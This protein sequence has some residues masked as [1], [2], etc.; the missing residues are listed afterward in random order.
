MIEIRVVVHPYPDWNGGIE[1]ELQYRHKL[2]EDE[3]YYD[4]KYNL[5]TWSEWK[6]AEVI[7][8]NET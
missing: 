8:A 5:V 1:K 2:P 7:S 4:S 6:T 3:M